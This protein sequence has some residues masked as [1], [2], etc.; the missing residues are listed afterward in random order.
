METHILGEQGNRH[1]MRSVVRPRAPG[2][3]E[4]LHLGFEEHFRVVEGKL[5]VP[6]NGHVHIAGPGEAVRVPPHA[7]HKFFNPTDSPAVYELEVP[8]DYALFLSQVYKFTND[9]PPPT[10]RLKYILQISR[11]RPDAWLPRPPLPVQ[12]VLFFFIEPTAR[13]LGYQRYYRSYVPQLPVTAPR[14]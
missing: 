6:V 2:P 12:R 9:Y 13:L 1:L 3:P 10:H 7:P 5:H 14:V 4:H 11:L 8:R